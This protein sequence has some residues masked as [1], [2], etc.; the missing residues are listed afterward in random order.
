MSGGIT[1][2][3]A[4]RV[5]RIARKPGYAA[6]AA[7]FRNGLFRAAYPRNAAVGL[8]SGISIIFTRLFAVFTPITGLWATLRKRSVT[9]LVGEW[10]L[11]GGNAAQGQVS[12]NCLVCAAYDPGYYPG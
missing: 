7:G 6:R 3:E 12:R 4:G 2:R 5:I 8:S 10:R 11:G 9:R 1:S